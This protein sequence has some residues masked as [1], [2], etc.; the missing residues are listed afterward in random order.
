[1]VLIALCTLMEQFKE[2]SWTLEEQWSFIYGYYVL[3]IV[4]FYTLPIVISPFTF[5]D[6][7]SLCP[8]QDIAIAFIG[9]CH[10][11]TET[12]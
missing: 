12:I 11:D 7:G 8:V 4:A 3:Y 1:M 10:L 9:Q 5:G 2:V 6:L